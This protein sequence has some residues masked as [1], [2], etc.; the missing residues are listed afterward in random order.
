[1]GYLQTY[2]RERNQLTAPFHVK[3]K[4]KIKKKERLILDP[5]KR[6]QSTMQ[7]PQTITDKRDMLTCNN[8]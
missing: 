4:K 1:M 7:V 2:V 3:I 5:T 6:V 8:T